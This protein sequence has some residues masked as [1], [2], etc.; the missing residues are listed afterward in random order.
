MFVG[1]NSSAIHMMGDKIESKRIGNQARVNT[2]PGYDG[3]VPT[4]QDA[5]R[6]SNEIG[7]LRVLAKFSSNS[8]RNDALG[9]HT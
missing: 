4:E 1:P 9:H 8:L 7:N 3:E 5:I 6:I 2:I